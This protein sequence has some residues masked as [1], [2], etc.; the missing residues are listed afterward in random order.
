MK[1]LA[2][3]LIDQCQFD[4]FIICKHCW[5]KI[6][7]LEHVYS[8]VCINILDIVCNGCL[9]SIIIIILFLTSMVYIYRIAVV[10]EINIILALFIYRVVVF[11]VV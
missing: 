6:A 7:T 11:D 4:Y 10:N 3:N 8:V 1:N 2:I 5:I 9:Q